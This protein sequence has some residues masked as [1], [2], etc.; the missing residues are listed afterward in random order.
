M[1]EPGEPCPHLNATIK[2]RFM[3]PRGGQAEIMVRVQA[4]C[5]DCAAH[6]RFL[7]LPACWIHDAPHPAGSE[8]DGTDNQAVYLPGL[9]TEAERG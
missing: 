1:T 6:L 3:I 9:W 7:G 4:H 8:D 2:A 5:P